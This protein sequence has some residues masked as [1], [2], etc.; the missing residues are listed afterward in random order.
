MDERIATYDQHICAMALADER[1]KR[2][3]QVRGIGATTASALLASI[4]NG[5]EF[6]NARQFAAWVGLTPGQYSSGGK[7]R[8]GR[9]T[10]AGDA[11]LRTLLILRWKKC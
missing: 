7:V 10:K 11:Y 4:G 3:M 1:S 9:I 6:D 2:L 8:L 5:H